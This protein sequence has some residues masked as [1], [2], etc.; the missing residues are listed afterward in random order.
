MKTSAKRIKCFG[1]FNQTLPDNSDS[2]LRSRTGLSLPGLL[3]GIRGFMVSCFTGW[4]L[5]IDYY[6]FLGFFLFAY[7]TVFSCPHNLLR[8]SSDT[9]TSVYSC[10]W[11]L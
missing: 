1:L 2:L 6:L 4:T 5:L 8:D 9:V 7:I 11:Q 3:S 10:K